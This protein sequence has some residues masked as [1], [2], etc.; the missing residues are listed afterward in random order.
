MTSCRFCVGSWC[1]LNDPAVTAGIAS[2]H[3]CLKLDVAQTLQCKPIMLGPELQHGLHALK[4]TYYTCVSHVT[5]VYFG[6]NHHTFG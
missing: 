2:G 4:D 5:Y 1:Q 6:L 3:L